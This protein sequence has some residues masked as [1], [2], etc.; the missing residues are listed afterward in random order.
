MT[1]THSLAAEQASSTCTHVLQRIAIPFENCV[2]RNIIHTEYFAY[3]QYKSVKHESHYG[4]RGFRTETQSAV[5]NR[6]YTVRGRLPRKT[7][8]HTSHRSIPARS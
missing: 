8:D 5:H 4:I 1:A 3:L 7:V 6:N 2:F